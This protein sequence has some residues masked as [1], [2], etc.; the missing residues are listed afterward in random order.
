MQPISPENKEKIAAIA[1]SVLLFFVLLELYARFL[2]P[3][4]QQTPLC[5]YMADPTTGFR[6]EPN[7]STRFKTLE[8]DTTVQINSNGLR[9]DK[10]GEKNGARVLF[11]GDSFV[12]GHGVELDESVSKRLQQRLLE[13]TGKRFEVISAGL[14]ASGTIREVQWL[15]SYGLALKPDWVIVGFFAG[16]DFVDNQTESNG[17]NQFTVKGRCLASASADGATTSI[18][19]VVLKNIYSIRFLN[20]RIKSFQPVRSALSAVGLASAEKIPPSM[21]LYQKPYRGRLSEGLD[22]TRDSFAELKS[23]SKENNFKVLIV[24]I[25]S[26]TEADSKFFE[27]VLEQHQLDPGDFNAAIPGEWVKGLAE[28]NKFAVTDLQPIFQQSV[29]QG[30][31]LYYSLDEHWNAKGH[32]LAAEWIAEDGKIS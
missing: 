29:S 8:F 22:A 25:P 28:E 14:S 13:K 32:A 23:L 1:F 10:I 4:Y 17:L 6:L 7:Y 19:S 15:K 24:I 26:R 31:G 30:N 21:E 3:E 11:L 5:A 18:Q 27:S 12:F 20:D 9:D 16:N 2:V